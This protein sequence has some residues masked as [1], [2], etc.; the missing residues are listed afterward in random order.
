MSGRIDNKIKVEASIERHI[1]DKPSYVVEYYYSISNAEHKTKLTYLYNICQYLDFLKGRGV[2]INN[3]QNLNQ[4]NTNMFFAA[5]RYTTRGGVKKPTSKSMFNTMRSSLNSFFKYMVACDYVLKNPIDNIKRIKGTDNVK[6]I[7]MQ[8]DDVKNVVRDVES[9][10]QKTG[11]DWKAIRD[12]AMISILI[13]T[14]IRATALTEIDINDIDD[15]GDVMIIRITD[16][17][18]KYYQRQMSGKFAQ[19]VRNWLEVRKTMERQLKN[20]AVFVGCRYDRITT[21]SVRTIIAKYSPVIDG[22]QVTPHKYRATYGT[23]LYKAT[24][25]IYY[26]QKQMGHASPSTTEIYI[27]DSGEDEAKASDIM[28]RL[29]G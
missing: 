21:N 5:I 18:D 22:K 4:Q 9:E 26:V 24:H 6:R 25:D 29:F 11:N 27:V 14:G 8:E 15:T 23:T 12:L 19:N 17:E 7:Y 16:K 1:E 13:Q 28:A 10:I 2:D 20:D 3:P